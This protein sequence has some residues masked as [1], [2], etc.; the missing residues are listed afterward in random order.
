MKS[1]RNLLRIILRKSGHYNRHPCRRRLSFVRRVL[2]PFL[3]LLLFSIPWESLSIGTGTDNVRPSLSGPDLGHLGNRDVG[4]ALSWVK[5]CRQGRKTDSKK[6]V[7]AMEKI[8]FDGG[9]G[10]SSTSG[11][12]TT[13]DAAHLVACG[14]K[15]VRGKKKRPVGHLED[16]RRGPRQERGSR[17]HRL[18]KRRRLQMTRPE[19]VP[20]H[21]KAPFEPRKGLCFRRRP[22][23]PGHTVSPRQTCAATPA[24]APWRGPR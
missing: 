22:L 12:G 2:M 6:V 21:T 11:R 10:G 20:I 15:E 24:P 8:K 18:T 13:I 7:E 16:R 4:H 3:Q 1:M 5:Q 19:F 9:R 23:V 17:G 14:K